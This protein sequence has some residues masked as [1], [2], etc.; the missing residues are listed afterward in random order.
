MDFDQDASKFIGDPSKCVT[1]DAKFWI[2][3]VLGSY[4]REDRVYKWVNDGSSGIQTHLDSPKWAKS[5]PNGLGDQECAGALEFNGEWFWND[6]HCDQ[7]HM[8]SVCSVPPVKT[9][10]LRGQFPP[11]LGEMDRKYSFIAEKQ[12][13]GSKVVFYGHTGL[14]KVVWFPFEKRTVVLHDGKN[15]SIESSENHFGLLNYY[16]PSAHD[17]ETYKVDLVFTKVRLS[18]ISQQLLSE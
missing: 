16:D 6:M 2:P 15:Y 7:D 11:K 1:I 14:T 3:I 10:Y 4:S 8:C 9:Y 13:V 18:N 5:Q 17:W 12:T